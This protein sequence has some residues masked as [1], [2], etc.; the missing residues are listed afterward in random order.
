MAG[1]APFISQWKGGDF[2]LGYLRASAEAISAVAVL[3]TRAAAA[4]PYKDGYWIRTPESDSSEVWC[5]DHIDAAVAK[6]RRKF[7]KDHPDEIRS[8]RCSGFEEDSRLFC[9]TC[10]APIQAPLTDYGAAEE[11][12]H[13]ADKLRRL[14]NLDQLS[15]DEARELHEVLEQACWWESSHHLSSLAKFLRVALPLLPTPK[16]AVPVAQ[17]KIVDATNKEGVAMSSITVRLEGP[18]AN[19]RRLLANLD[20]AITHLAAAAPPELLALQQA[21]RVPE[22]RPAAAQ[23]TISHPAA[24]LAAERLAILAR[25]ASLGSAVTAAGGT[26]NDRAPLSDAVRDQLRRD[27]GDIMG[28]AARKHVTCD[29]SEAA[30][31]GAA[32]RDHF[33]LGCWLHYYRDR[34]RRDGPQGF[35]DR[36]DCARR[37]FEAG[38]PDPGYQFFTVFDFGERQVDAL[39]EMG[40]G[41]QV[42]ATLLAM[43]AAAPGGELARSVRAMGWQM[44]AARSSAAASVPSP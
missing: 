32:A 6:F 43:A 2:K 17:P 39:F 10:G 31:E 5:G 27:A 9:D 4:T 15:A 21:L 19:I 18:R 12:N 3:E 22:W 36:I 34:I 1:I 42:K 44:P 23:V 24:A 33:E 14:Q 38:M 26:V 35:A 30:A 8:V 40:D 13:F 20:N 28:T 37:L 25:A 16:A 7:R 29:R 41:S 11:L